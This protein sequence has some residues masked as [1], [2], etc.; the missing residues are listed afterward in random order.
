MIKKTNIHVEFH[1]FESAKVETLNNLEIVAWSLDLAAKLI[2]AQQ[3]VIATVQPPKMWA[4]VDETPKQTQ[5]HEPEQTKIPETKIPETDLIGRKMADAVWDNICHY[6]KADL[7]ASRGRTTFDSAP[8]V[9]IRSKSLQRTVVSI[10]MDPEHPMLTWSRSVDLG[11]FCESLDYDDTNRAYII[12]K[13]DVISRLITAGI[14]PTD[15]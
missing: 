1:M 4:V 8:V 13:D 10:C 2:R 3:A 6:E 5:I 11:K 15:Y 12:M 14:L 7:V 9:N